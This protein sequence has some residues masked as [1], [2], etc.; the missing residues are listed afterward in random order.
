MCCFNP[1]SVKNKTLALYDFITSH[2]Y[3][4]VTITETWLGSSIDK[5]CISE[6]VSEG[7]NFRHISRPPNKE[8]GGVALMFKSSIGFKLVKNDNIFIHFES[9]QCDLSVGVTCLRLAVIYRSWPTKA[10]GFRNSVF[11]DEWGSFLTKYVTFGGDFMMVGDF[12][13]HVD[14]LD[15]DRDAH[16]FMSMLEDCGMTQH[17][18][19]ATHVHGHT[20]DLIITSAGAR[21]LV[22]DIQVSDPGLCG[23]D[24]KRIRDHFCQTRAY[25]KDCR[26]QKVMQN[27]HQLFPSRDYGFFCRL[28]QH[29]QSG[30]TG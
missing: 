6:V 25:Q 10:N 20:L 27:Q 4:L 29:Q 17:V 21:S 30:R 15:N 7:Y 11:F 22:T 8:G 9:L 28:S 19:E 1:R 12:N 3:D 24:G 18:A 5:K 23:Q 13:F 16:R 26:I 14:D 2:D